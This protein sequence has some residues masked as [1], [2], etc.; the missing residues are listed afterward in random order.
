M[1]WTLENLVII[2]VVYLAGWITRALVIRKE[3]DDE[4]IYDNGWRECNAHWWDWF[5]GQRHDAALHFDDD[6]CQTESSQPAF[7]LVS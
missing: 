1:E 5:R 3:L 2:L 4:N 6:E 7:S